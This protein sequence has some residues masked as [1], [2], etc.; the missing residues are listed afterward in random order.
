V[1][2]A[3]AGTL[4][5]GG[6]AVLVVACATAERPIPAAPPPTAHMTAMSGDPHAQIEQL[7]QQI[8]AQRDQLGLPPPPAPTIND[9]DCKPTCMIEPMAVAARTQDPG[10]HPAGTSTCD[11]VCTLSDSICSN[12]TQVCNLARQ[13]ATDA[14][15]AGKCSEAQASCTAAHGRCCDCR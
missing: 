12:A 15:A 9:S 8:A 2:A 7:S 6:L 5:G 1:R 11:S 13:L 14:W 4:L 3:I 10:C